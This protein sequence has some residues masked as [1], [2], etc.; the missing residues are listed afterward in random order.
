M[1]WSDRVRA[2]WRL[3]PGDPRMERYVVF[4]GRMALAFAAAVVAA[5]IWLVWEVTKGMA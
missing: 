1:S 3:E 5:F 2:Y 4:W